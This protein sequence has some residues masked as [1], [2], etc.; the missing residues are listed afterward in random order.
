[1]A[2]AAS[3]C[4]DKTEISSDGENFML[5]EC[6]SELA[7]DKLDILEDQLTKFGFET[8]LDEEFGN[9]AI[10]LTSSSLSFTQTSKNH[11]EDFY[12]APLCDDEN[13][14]DE[15]QQIE[16]DSSSNCSDIEISTGK[17]ETVVKEGYLTKQGGFVRNWKERYFKLSG[18]YLSYYRECKVCCFFEFSLNFKVK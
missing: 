13:V 15:K 7:D 6:L 10:H 17:S 8:I 18:T 4:I 14:E 11:Q 2:E 5:E 9:S 3:C 1:M 12:S 16:K